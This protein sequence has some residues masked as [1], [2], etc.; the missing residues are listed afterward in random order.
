MNSN[1]QKFKWG[2][3]TQDKLYQLSKKKIPT[4]DTINF[5]LYNIDKIDN[6]EFKL[7][8]IMGYNTIYNAYF[9]KSD[10]TNYN[11]TTPELALAL[12]YLN[13]FDKKN[14]STCLKKLDSEILGSWIEYGLVKSNSNFLG[15][16]HKDIIKQEILTGFFG[17]ENYNLWDKRPIRQKVLV[18]YKLSNRIDIWEWQRCLSLPDSDWCV[19]NI[20]HIII[21]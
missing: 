8:S 10:F 18:K 4:N 2:W 16:W 19:S 20:N 13:Y 6:Q 11:F 21:L 5:E 17:P 9:E 7:G 3:I 1:I 12:N 15:L 14:Y